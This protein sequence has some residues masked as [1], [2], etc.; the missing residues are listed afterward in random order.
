MANIKLD[1]KEVEKN[2]NTKLDEKML[3]KIS[4]FGAS[5]NLTDDSLEIEV[6][7]NRPDMLSM[8][9]FLR[10]IKA[11]LGKETGLKKYRIF[12][13]ETNFKVKIE[14]SVK[15]VRPF[16]ACAVVTDLKLDD[17]KIKEVIDIQEKLHA[18]LGRN[19]R[20]V[21]IGIYPL[22]KI[23]L[24]I[25]YL[26]LKPEEIKFVPLGMDI[27]LNAAQI[28]QKHPAGREYA[29]LL[30]G[31]EKFPVF[32]DANKR[33][34]SMPPIINSNDTGKI[35]TE[36]RDVFIECSGFDFN[37]LKKTLNIIATALADMGGRIYAMEIN[38]E[39]G[40]KE[41]T[42]DLTP[43]K[44]KVNLD[45]V[46]SLLGT[47]LKEKDIEKLLK[48]MGYDYKS[49]RVLVPAWRTDILHEVDIIE[50]IAIGYGYDN[51]IPSIPNIATVGEESHKEK[52]KSRISNILIGLELLEISSYHLIRQDEAKK[53]KLE[54]PIE[55]ESSKTDYK[56][57][58]PNLLIPALRV[59]AENVD[60]EYPQRIFEIGTVFSHDAKTETGI[61]EKTNLLIALTPGNFTEMK[62]VLDYLTKAIGINYDL[63]ETLKQG[64]IDGRT[65]SIIIDG[66]EIGY[67]G[68]VHPST[69]ISWHLK[70]PLAVL[71]LDLD[72]VFKVV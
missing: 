68:E 42:P 64:L 66:K 9:G 6:L 11:F 20:K 22:D 51:L 31:C 2:L 12:K 5:A 55:V 19:R 32:I 43:E 61:S 26:A 41:T 14:P 70:M 30:A 29:G 59:L 18:T 57:L 56:I 23:N 67:F 45:N 13:P 34:L 48:L 49:S 27:E 7:P 62:Q 72:E 4:M 71:E 47:S 28:L 53:A 39:K 52:L 54:K 17:A 8:Q 10:A 16:T 50:D 25:K 46:N 38:Y 69:L 40:G 63:K 44:I 37:V 65:A 3:D 1:R 15:A 24:P 60:N 36:T 58:R 33:V 21:A 35:S